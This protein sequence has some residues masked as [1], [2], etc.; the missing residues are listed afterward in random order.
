MA[1][2]SSG[3]SAGKHES[4]SGEQGSVPVNGSVNDPVGEFAAESA[5]EFT[6][7]SVGEFAAESARDSVSGS[8]SDFAGRYPAR[9][10]QEMAVIAAAQTLLAE[11]LVA[12]TWGNLSARISSDRFVITPSGRDYRDLAGAD[13]VQVNLD[14]EWE[15]THKPSGEKGIHALIYRERPDAKF[16]IHTHQPYASALSL[17]AKSYKLPADLQELLGA[18]VLP[19]ASY[20]L[21]GTKKLHKAMLEAVRR[22]GARAVL[23]RAHGL[24]VFG[25]DAQEAL[26]IARAV[27]KFCR[28]VYLTRV[29]I[30]PEDDVQVQDGSGSG[31]VLSAERIWTRS[32]MAARGAGAYGAES[33]GVAADGMATGGSATNGM[34][35]QNRAQA[36]AEAAL[37]SA[38]LGPEEQAKAEVAALFAARPDVHCIIGESDPAV[39]AHS[40][41]LRPYLDDFSQIVG[42]K[43]GTVEHS[44]RSARGI[45]H[46][47]VFGALKKVGVPDLGLSNAA[48]GVYAYCMGKDVEDAQAVQMVLHKNALAASFGRTYAA[49]PL[50]SLDGALQHAVYALQYSKLKDES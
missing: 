50:G 45:V 22:T 44:V 11:G 20:G 28:S 19:I 38:A 1:Q 49:K 34:A 24:L 42:L 23:M 21:P 25:G 12:R 40:T 18:R 7:D 30:V 46:G 47:K 6:S 13:L 14:G 36:G 41:G 29:S 8:A 16:I 33:S 27:E 4:A 26:A 2:Q 31:G 5:R 35:G 43:A 3:K 32:G 10:Q 48:F 39:L 15:G 17:G 9:E 37:E